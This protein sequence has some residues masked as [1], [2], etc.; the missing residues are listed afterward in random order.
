VHAETDRVQRQEAAERARAQL[1]DVAQLFGSPLRA[2]RR[3]A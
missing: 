1:P 2:I 3:T